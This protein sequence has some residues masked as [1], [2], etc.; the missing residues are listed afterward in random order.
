MA[1]C[2]ACRKTWKSSSQ[3]SSAGISET[4][5]AVM[6]RRPLNES[7]SE[8]SSS[9]AR[10]AG[11]TGATVSSHFAYQLLGARKN[12]PYPKSPRRTWMAVTDGHIDRSLAT[13]EFSR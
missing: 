11:E 4:S 1:T 2:S 6:I 3:S 5:R 10:Y 13:H 8:L 7:H 12:G 9:D